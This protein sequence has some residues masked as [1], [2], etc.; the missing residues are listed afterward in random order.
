MKSLKKALVMIVMLMAFLFGGLLSVNV[1]AEKIK[2]ERDDNVPGVDG[3]SIVLP[4][5]EFDILGDE[6][7][8][9]DEYETSGDEEDTE[10]EDK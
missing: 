2:W 1:N 7:P 8:E 9:D 3:C 6:D 5:P 10:D 4:E